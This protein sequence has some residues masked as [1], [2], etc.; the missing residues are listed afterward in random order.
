MIGQGGRS[1]SVGGHTLHIKR[2][3]DGIQSFKGEI[4]EGNNIGYVNIQ[5]KRKDI[6]RIQAF[7]K[8]NQSAI[9]DNESK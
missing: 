1:G 9:T 6:T 5:L 4:R 2:R 3:K 7:L 8:W